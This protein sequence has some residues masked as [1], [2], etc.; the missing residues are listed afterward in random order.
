MDN[1]TELEDAILRHIKI[2]ESEIKDKD[3]FKQA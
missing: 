3:A 2:M 1:N